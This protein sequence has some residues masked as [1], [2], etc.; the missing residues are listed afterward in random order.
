MFDQQTTAYPDLPSVIFGIVALS[1]SAFALFIPEMKS[2][3]MKD[4]VYE[5]KDKELQSD[6]DK[7]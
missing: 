6:S 1:A 5:Y 4:Q 7:P 2:V 3:D